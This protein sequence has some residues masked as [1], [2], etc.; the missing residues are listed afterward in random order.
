MSLEQYRD[1]KERSFDRYKLGVQ[2]LPGN[3]INVRPS[4][5]DK[6]EKD[7]FD[8]AE[9]KETFSIVNGY[10]ETDR[11]NRHTVAQAVVQTLLRDDGTYP[12]E[13]TVLSKA[14]SQ[15]PSDAEWD[16]MLTNPEPAVWPDPY[17]FDPAEYGV[18]A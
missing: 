15:F 3:K 5:Q 13:M 1:L 10:P 12:K 9:Y 6:M 7:A 2:V 17:K 4:N 18:E 16:E 11:S 8:K 14:L